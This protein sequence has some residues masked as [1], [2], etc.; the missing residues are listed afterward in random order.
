MSEM[1]P[2][3][4]G[5]R[6]RTFLLV[7]ARVFLGAF[8]ILIALNQWRG[9]W[10][11]GTGMQ[12]EWGPAVETMPLAPL[13]A[14]LTKWVLHFGTVGG[15]IMALEF[16]VGALLILGFGVRLMSLLGMV[17]TGVET[18]VFGCSVRLVPVPGQGEAATQLVRQNLELH[19]KELGLYGLMF[20]VLLVFLFTG[21]GRSFGLDGF[22]WRRSA[23][24]LA[25]AKGQGWE[26]PTTSSSQ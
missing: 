13:K 11:A 26:P 16:V 8:F 6:T 17:L 7:P 5:V 15:I 21:A 20:F 22:L 9:G 3:N 19:T 14:F 12:A 4:F 1:V 2:G 23:R 10:F 18:L 24:R 25:Q